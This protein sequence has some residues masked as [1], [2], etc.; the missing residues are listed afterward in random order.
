MPGGGA[1]PAEPAVRRGTR[2]GLA[3]AVPGRLDQ[4][5]LEDGLRAVAAA[6]RGFARALARHG[7]PTLRARPPGFATLLRIVVGQQL[8]TVAA[9]TIWGRL[10]EATTGDPAGTPTPAALT[11]LD[12]DAL[13]A[14]GLSGRKATYARGLAEAV[15]TRRLDLASLAAVDDD[16]CIDALTSVRGIGV[17]SAEIYLLFALG[18]RDVFPAGDLGLRAAL[19]RLRLTRGRPDEARAREVAARRFAPHRSAVAIFLWRA[20]DGP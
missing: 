19:E 15:E 20:L 2:G 16:A 17:W 7:A 14:A 11:A 9:R 13:R 3:A 4:A 5:S 1:G 12:D 18:R 10:A 6:D 8:S